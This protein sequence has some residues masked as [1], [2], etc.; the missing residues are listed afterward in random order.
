M[1]CHLAILT[2]VMAVAAPS[3]AHAYNYKFCMYYHATTV[4]S[5]NGE[6]YYQNT[7]YW[8]A[9]GAKV[10]VRTI[11]WPYST[12]YEGYARDDYG[13]FEFSSSGQQFYVDL[14]AETRLGQSGNVSLKA[15]LDHSNNPGPVSYWTI[16]TSQLSGGTHHLYGPASRLSNLIGIGS[17]VFHWFDSRSGTR[18]P[19]DHEV[20]LWDDPCPGYPNNSCAPDD[21]VYINPDLNNRKFHIGHEMGHRIMYM[22]RG[23]WPYNCTYNEDPACSYLPDGE[24][25]LHSKEYSTCAISEAWAHFVSVDAFNSHDQTDAHFQYYK[26]TIATDVNVE[27]GNV[28]GATAYMESVCTEPYGGYGVEL[29]WLRTFWDYHTN[30]NPGGKPS[31]FEIMDQLD[32][33]YDH[34]QFGVNNAWIKIYE[35][36]LNDGF[37]PRFLEMADW[38]GVNHND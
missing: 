26:T 30:S 12:V 29:D 28:G 19:G 15:R 38:N 24:H 22:K 35:A 5:G 23:V 3:G 18:M 31:H 36:A 2:F 32:A 4:D 9:R 33:A 27:N 10:R 14:Y 6:D 37:G 17:F 7:S 25:S 20:N 21:D 34:P 1:K 11:S 8:R 16:L 13:C